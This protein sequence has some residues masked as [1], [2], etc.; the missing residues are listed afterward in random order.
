MPATIKEFYRGDTKNYAFDFGCG[1]DITGW[2]I[3]FTLKEKKGDADSAA[4][5]QVF[6]VA[7]DNPGDD[8]LDGKMIVTAHAADTASLI[9]D[10]TYFYGF[11]RVAPGYAAGVPDDVR[12]LLTGAVRVLQDI[13]VTTV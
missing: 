13:T 1:V 2:K 3:Y 5:V 12:T 6:N 11:Q 10:T 4:T 8:I 7:G 9:P